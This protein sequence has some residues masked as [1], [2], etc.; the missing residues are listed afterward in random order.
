M[1]KQFYAML[2]ML[3]CGG[4]VG[5]EDAHLPSPLVVTAVSINDGTEHGLKGKY[6]VTFDGQCL[7]DAK[8]YT[9]TK[10]S[11]GDTLK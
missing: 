8:Y 3:T 7:V 1:K 4:L 9:D 5:C 10:Y 11:V 2:V 6:I